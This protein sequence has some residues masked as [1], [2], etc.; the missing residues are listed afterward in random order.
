MI[1]G[2]LANATGNTAILL[3][4]IMQRDMQQ[5]YWLTRNMYCAYTHMCSQAC[6]CTQL[7]EETAEK[8]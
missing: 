4:T 3:L 8:G 2:C 7:P 6:M 1:W 5:K